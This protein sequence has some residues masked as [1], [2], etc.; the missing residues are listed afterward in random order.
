MKFTIVIPTLNRA[1]YIKYPIESILSQKGVHDFKIIVS[2]NC[3]DDNTKE[4]ILAYMESN[5]NIQ[6]IRPSYRMSMSK[7]WEFASKF[8]SNNDGYIMYLGDDDILSENTFNIASEIFKK[9][10]VDAV[11]RKTGYYYMTECESPL[12]GYLLLESIDGNIEIRDSIENLK[13]V[14]EFKTHYGELPNLYHGFV[15]VNHL[16]ELRDKKKLFNKAAPDIYSDIAL[17]SLNIKYASVNYPLTLGV[18]SPKSNGFN[19]S[20]KNKISLD[21]TESSYKDFKHTY[22]MDIITLHIL[23]CLEDV[24]SDEQKRIKINYKSCYNNI[25]IE[26]SFSNIFKCRKDIKKIS[27]NGMLKIFFDYF[28]RALHPRRL[29]RVLPTKMKVFL[30]EKYNIKQQEK[31]KFNFNGDLKKLGILNPKDCILF[32]ENNIVYSGKVVDVL[33]TSK[34]EK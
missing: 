19:F 31:G 6:Y 28:Y 3:S 10:N 1:E 21:F 4:I 7:H 15:K 11:R 26:S 22:K 16:I 12:A 30:K 2:D 13:N 34:K 17:A 9:Y 5:N 14:A 25:M 29:G 8:L 23:D 24:L 20:K 32:I 27:G 33:N 18:A